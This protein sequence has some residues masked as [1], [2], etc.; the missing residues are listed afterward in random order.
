M[1]L[2]FYIFKYTKSSRLN[3]LISLNLINNLNSIEID[4]PDTE[5]T[6]KKIIR[7]LKIISFFDFNNQYI[8]NKK[9][10]DVILSER[11]NTEF[12][13]NDIKFILIK[14]YEAFV[15]IYEKDPNNKS[16]ESLGKI[17][18]NDFIIYSN[19]NIFNKKEN[20]YIMKL[21]KVNNGILFE[22]NKIYFY[23]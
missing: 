23:E 20:D 16:Y 10:I 11:E 14:I 22:N 2:F 6:K 21:F 7:N 4:L 12:D 15:N 8:D 3:F 9:H 18:I 1:L 13:F 17:L 19:K 5:K